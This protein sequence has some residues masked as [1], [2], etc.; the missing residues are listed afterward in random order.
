MAEVIGRL[1][2]AVD[3]Y[4]ARPGVPSEVIM[5]EFKNNGIPLH[6]DES[7]TS[8]LEMNME[9]IKRLLQFFS[10]T[11]PNERDG[12]R[13]FE[14]KL[15]GH[16][17]CLD[18]NIAALTNFL[19]PG[20]EE[21]DIENPDVELGKIFNKI[22]TRFRDTTL[23]ESYD[24]PTYLTNNTKTKLT[25]K[26]FRDDKIRIF[27]EK[28]GNDARDKAI[29]FLDIMVRD[30]V[31]EGKTVLSLYDQDNNDILERLTAEFESVKEAIEF[32][33]VVSSKRIEAGT[34]IQLENKDILKNEFA[35]YGPYYMGR[36]IIGVNYGG[37]GGKMPGG[38][39]KS[40]RARQSRKS[41]R[42]K[43]CRKSRRLVK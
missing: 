35:F 10:E 30:Y 26:F 13:A 43:K 39:R 11:Y 29:K 22:I 9:N 15:M 28:Y 25:E 6:S 40:R 34:Y 37:G 1:R 23:E 12:I 7:N 4:D 2:L 38:K 3:I 33:P 27:M 32:Q 18:S 42:Q 20:K 31:D 5:R 16:P 21:I 24:L 19:F 17:V 8:S 36:K 41:R 14:E